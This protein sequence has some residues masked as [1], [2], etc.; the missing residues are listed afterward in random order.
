M[1]NANSK[2]NQPLTFR[3][4]RERVLC[5][6]LP[7]RRPRESLDAEGDPVEAFVQRGTRPGPPV[8]PHSRLRQG[9][10]PHRTPAFPRASSGYGAAG[11]PSGPC[12]RDGV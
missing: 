12:P 8:A 10:R 5:H 1:I 6:P 9:G 2:T 11:I 3:G 7:Q 4:G